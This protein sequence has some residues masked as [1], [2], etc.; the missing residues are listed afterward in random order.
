MKQPFAPL[1]VVATLAVAAPGACKRPGARPASAQAPTAA[2]AP[3]AVAVAQPKTAA[4]GRVVTLPGTVRPEK[5]ATLYAKVAGY[6]KTIRVDRGD[7]VRAGQ[8]LAELEAPE[9]LADLEKQKA[10]VS[11]A[12]SNFKRLSEAQAKA[13]NLVTPLAV[14]EANGR[15]EIARAHLRRTETLLSY[16][17]ITA[18]FAG[19]VT[20][21]W[22]DPGAFIPSATAGSVAQ[23][24][25]LLTL[26]DLGTVRIEVPIPERE[27]P[28]VKTGLPAR[29]AVDELPGRS[30][31]GKITRMG[32]SLDER[33]R[34][35]AAEVSLKN[36][37]EALRPGMYA[38]VQIEIQRKPEALVVPLG[39]LVTEKGK[40][41]VFTVAD[42]KARK[43]AVKTGFRDVD[44]VEILEG[45]SLGQP[46]LLAGKLALADGQPVSATE[47]P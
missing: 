7:R 42:N 26:V 43:L 3:V 2:A 33:T 18:P 38:S 15:H 9:L 1:F 32:Y 46:V 29:V 8:P 19:V 21:R 14:D 22:V 36:P 35:M 16:T 24:A 31:E 45:I 37:D 6:L 20:R 28:L 41:F 12:G 34:T 11:V 44:A 10:E 30:F 47:A 13:P 23:S 39:A 4:I 5:Q 17:R 25:A 27:V 40:G